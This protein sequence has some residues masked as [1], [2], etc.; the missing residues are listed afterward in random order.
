MTVLFVVIMGTLILLFTAWGGSVIRRRT[1]RHF[2]RSGNVRP[3]KKSSTVS[4]G[5]LPNSS[6][7]TSQSDTLIIPP[8]QNMPK[9]IPGTEVDS[10]QS[11]ETKL[12]SY[13]DDTHASG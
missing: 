9:N 13:H 6:L 1:R 3:S 7:P 8:D 11:A 4:P 5:A 10:K 2:R 12:D